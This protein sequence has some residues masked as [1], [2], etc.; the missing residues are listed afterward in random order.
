[1]GVQGVVSFVD[2]VTSLKG[3]RCARGG[4]VQMGQGRN[5]KDPLGGQKGLS[6]AQ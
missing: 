5:K 3:G 4:R 2:I 6:L 1:V